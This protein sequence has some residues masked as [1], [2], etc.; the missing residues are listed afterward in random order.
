MVSFFCVGFD[1]ALEDPP[2]IRANCSAGEQESV[3]KGMADDIATTSMAY[4]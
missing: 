3:C 4:L 2:I 1:P